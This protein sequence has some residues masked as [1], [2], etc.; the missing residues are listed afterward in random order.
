METFGEVVCK[1][2]DAVM[3]LNTIRSPMHV[4]YNGKKAY[5]LRIDN[6]TGFN[7]K[8]EFGTVLTAVRMTLDTAHGCWLLDNA[9]FDYAEPQRARWDHFHNATEAGRKRKG[10]FEKDVRKDHD[11]L[12]IKVSDQVGLVV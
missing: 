8:V 6:S 9:D 5:H 4:S 12:K 1:W 10:P 3:E 11:K 2:F 7:D